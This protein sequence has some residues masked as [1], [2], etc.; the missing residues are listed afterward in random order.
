MTQII[1]IMG[2][3]KEEIELFLKAMADIQE[4]QRAEITFYQ[5]RMHEKDVIL[6]QSGV[7]KVNA[8]VCTQILI[9][10]Y[11]VDYIIFTGV[12]GG[13]DPQLNIGDIVISTECQ[14]HDIDASPVGFKKGEIPFAETSVFKADPFLIR[15]AESYRP[16]EDTVQIVKGKILSGDQFIADPE[17]VEQL[18]HMFNGSCVEM[19]GAAVAQVCHLNQVPFVIIRSLSDKADRKA[20]INFAEFTKVAA[21]RSYELVDHMLKHWQTVSTA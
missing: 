19:E 3:M 12:A 20:N 7:G 1:G 8:S 9:D 2:A 16:E 13:V 18:Y 17:H 21:R 15:L 10:D 4:K 5:G 6:C 14:Q 11:D